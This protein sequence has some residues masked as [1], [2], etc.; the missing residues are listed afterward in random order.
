MKSKHVL[1]GLILIVLF[2]DFGTVYSQN[3][4]ELN[5][6]ELFYFPKTTDGSDVMNNNI[7]SIKWN[8]SRNRSLSKPLFRM[9]EPVLFNKLDATVFRYTHIGSW[10]EPYTIRLELKGGKVVLD[11]KET[12]GD[13][14][15]I[16]DTLK[17]VHK[18]LPTKVWKKLEVKVDSCQF[19]TTP[20]FRVF[21]DIVIFDGAEWILEGVSSNKYHFVMRN[22]PDKYGD[23]KF[24]ALCNYIERLV[25]E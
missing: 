18:E 22:T 17:I 19:W 6:D 3:E 9:D 25:N 16:S 20:S 11:Y 2:G 15:D 7:V 1:I 8:D 12:F 14:G 24:A 4:E 21:K 23:E 5:G 10:S 13:G